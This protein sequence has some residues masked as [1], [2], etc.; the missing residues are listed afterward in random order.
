MGGTQE[1]FRKRWPS[2]VCAHTGGMK[3]PESVST[4]RL[5]VAQWTEKLSR[6]TGV[7]GGGAG[8][9]VMLSMAAALICM[10]AGYSED[11][12][13]EGEAG[14]IR[15]RGQ[16]LRKESLQ[17]ADEDAACSASFGE[18]FHIPSGPARAAAIC[19]AALQAARSSAAIGKR[20][21]AAVDDIRWLAEYGNQA[22]VAD[23]VVALGALRASISGC[24]AN[25]CFDLSTLQ[26]H[27]D[28]GQPEGEAAPLH[29]TLEQLDRALASIDKLSADIDARIRERLSDD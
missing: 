29:G 13:V 15:R 8:S 19:G 18:A 17:L 12:A 25:V 4:Q 2:T 28:S 21:A 16:I 7:P 11:A 1:P 10:A 24:R 22:L 20:A 9:G 3:K 26:A 6:T 5:T 27:R 23:M 14:R